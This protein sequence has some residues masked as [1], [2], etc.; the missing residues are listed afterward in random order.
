MTTHDLQDLDP[1]A[2]ANKIA[3][4]FARISQS[5][6]P[7]SADKLPSFLPAQ[8]APVIEE[9]QVYLEL[10]RMKK[11]K[12]TLPIDLPYKLRKEFAPELAVPLTNIFNSCLKEGKYP[13]MW[14]YEWVTPIPKI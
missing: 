3:S 2:A 4:H 8:P 9:Y 1:P 5:Y 7:I 13:A 14:K 10:S 11:T 12:S 6:E